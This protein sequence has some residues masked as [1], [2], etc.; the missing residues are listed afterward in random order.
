M[1]IATARRLCPH[2]IF[3]PGHH[4]LYRDYS[5]RLMALLETYAPL[6]EKV[7]LDEAYVDLSGTERLF[8]PPEMTARLIQKRVK[9]ESTDPSPENQ[10]HI[11]DKCLYFLGECELVWP[12]STPRGRHSLDAI[13][14]Q[15]GSSVSSLL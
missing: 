6:V 2:G 11:E 10:G 15:P 13:F 14:P 7:S 9:P 5:R 8:G 1:P 4:E 12:T 3:L